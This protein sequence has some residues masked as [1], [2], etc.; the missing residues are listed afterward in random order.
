MRI[1]P[2]TIASTRPTRMPTTASM[3]MLLE[4]FFCWNASTAGFH[5][6]YWSVRSWWKGGEVDGLLVWVLDAVAFGCP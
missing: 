5:W 3:L 1:V 2:R 6:L 4:D